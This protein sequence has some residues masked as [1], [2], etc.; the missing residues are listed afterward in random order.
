MHLSAL[1]GMGEI[2]MR[3]CLPQ[4]IWYGNTTLEIDLLEDWDV[5]YCPMH[6]ALRPSLSIEQM[7]A[8]IRNPIGT[9]RLR[10][11]AKGKK[12]VVIVFDDMTRP[13]RTY[14]LAPIVLRELIEGG[15]REEVAFSFSPSDVFPV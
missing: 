13:T 9:P 12:R 6:G 5:A 14:E 10:E 4:L 3:I 1:R 15:V 7:E 11:L 8:M 2:E